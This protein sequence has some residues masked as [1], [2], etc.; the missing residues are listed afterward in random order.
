MGG[1][2]SMKRIPVAA[3]VVAALAVTLVACKGK[4]SQSTSAP[5]G[6]AT[7]PVVSSPEKVDLLT[8]LAQQF[9][10]SSAAK[11]GGCVFVQVKNVS[12]GTQATLL[13]E[14]WP[15]EATN[16]PK[17]VIFSPAASAWGGVVNQR[18]TAKGQQAIVP[19]TFKSFMLT[20]L[21]IAMPKPMADAL[22]YPATPIGYGDLLKLAQDPNGWAAKGHPEWGAFKLGK[23]NP[24][25]STS[26]L[27][28]TVAQYYAAT[29]KQ[30]DLSLEDVNR[31]EVAA[32]NQGVESSVVH[33][34]DTTLTFLNNWY[35][36]DSRGT[37]LTYVSAVSV[38]EKSVID[39]NKGNPDG[40]L[41]AGENPRPPRVPL[42][43]IYPKEGTLFSDE[44]L[45]ILNADWVSDR[46][47][48]GAQA[49]SDFVQ[50]PENQRQ[51]LSFGFRP[52][53]PQVPVGSPISKAYGV[54][55]GQPQTT[56]TVPS[57][58]VL[59]GI[60]DKWGEQRKSARVLLVIDVSGSMGDDAGD[61]TKLDL[62]KRAAIDA[63]QDFKA[64]DQVGLRI[65]STGINARGPD[66]DEL[67]LVAIGPIASNREALATRID[68]LVPT[69][70]TPLYSTAKNSY[71]FLKSSYDPKRINAVVLL[72]DGKNEDPNNNDFNS[73][74]NALRSGSEGLS[75]TPVRLFTIGYGKDADLATLRRMAE[76]TN[77]ASY[78]ASDPQTINKVFTAVVSNF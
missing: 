56:L 24:N 20:P 7:I 4:D 55:P 10:D 63:L 22:G 76:A 53:N 78:D 3:I 74:L 77:A 26:A 32:F 71:N 8:K 61:G 39:Y 60:I 57:P 34:G 15:D 69:S 33:Y 36:N 40:I 30:R 9:N 31:P 23:T 50:R 19:T 52:G 17:P 51:V 27:N 2:I 1:G 58:E 5:K 45:F 48:R 14:G 13:S 25:F 67:D 66:T 29:G 44:P 38:E 6:C 68:S 42:V 21:V 59:V 70:G 75:T 43:A 64:D 35:R 16:G 37:A 73:T 65:F 72:T 18:L 47:R 49:F 62:A 12:S 28:A 46:Q 41:Q 11:N 54:D